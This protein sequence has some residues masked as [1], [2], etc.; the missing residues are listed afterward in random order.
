MTIALSEFTYSTVMLPFFQLEADPL[1]I[2]TQNLAAEA[3]SSPILVWL[4]LIFSFLALIISCILMLQTRRM[5]T[6]SKFKVPNQEIF[7]TIRQHAEPPYPL[8]DEIGAALWTLVHTALVNGPRSSV[9]NLEHLRQE[10]R[11]N[12]RTAVARSQIA[13]S[14]KRAQSDN[15][16]PYGSNQLWADN[17]PSTSPVVPLNKPAT[18]VERTSQELS[19]P[20][21]ALTPILESDLHL[22]VI[23]RTSR[24]GNAGMDA[25]TSKGEFIRFQNQNNIVFF[26]LESKRFEE[27]QAPLLAAERWLFG[28]SDAETGLIS[29]FHG[30][31][32]LSSSQ[33]IASNARDEAV[34]FLPWFEVTVKGMQ[35]VLE[36][37]ALVKVIGKTIHV[38]RKG[39]MSI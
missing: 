25:M 21:R 34:R 20:S 37:P 17:Q 33:R 14:V 28:V 2:E 30:P 32:M 29:L 39:Q 11:D 31:A 9:D 26:D 12:E 24:V 1:S 10:A 6:N 5:S 7:E 18:P 16:E 35:P 15:Y 3:G 38:V 36:V 4:A 23:K 22:A 8:S 19:P 27:P 13:S